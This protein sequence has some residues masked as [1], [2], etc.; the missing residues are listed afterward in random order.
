M[1]ERERPQRLPEADPAQVARKATDGDHPMLTL[2]R[3]AGNAAFNRMIQPKLTV[4]HAHDPHEDEADRV[5]AEVMR[6]LQSGLPAEDEVQPGPGGV[7]RRAALP[8]IQLKS[9]DPL[10]GAAV[11]DDLEQQISSSSGRT[12]DTGTRGRMEG[13]FGADFSN[14]RIH[15]D[16]SA[17]AMSESLQA[18]AFTTGN[19]VFFRKGGY[20]PSSSGGQ[21]LLAHELTHVVQQQGGAAS[22]KIRR[23]VPLKEFQTRTDEGTF[24]A[25]S[26]AQKE[27]EKALTAY[28]KLGAAKEEK[29]KTKPGKPA[30]KIVIPDNK[31]DNAIALLEQMKAIAEMWIEAKTVD[32]EVGP[33][34]KPTA[35]IDPSRAKRGAGMAWFLM[36]CDG[37]LKSM[38]ARRSVEAV[39]VAQDEVVVDSK[40]MQKL[41]DKYQGSLSGGL[42]KAGFVLGK[43]C[44]NDG[45]S[46]SFELNLK[47]PVAPGA[48]IGGILRFEAKKDGN[49][50]VACE[51]MFQ[52]G[53]SVGIA[54]IH[55]ALGGYF[56]SSAKTPEGAM[57]LL[58]Y[59]FYR[60]C[61]ESSVIP[62][63]VSS[64]IWGGNTGEFGKKKADKWSLQVEKEELEDDD[65]YVETG[66]VG[67]V[68]ADLEL[69]VAQVGMAAKGTAGKRHDKASLTEAKGGAGKS[70]TGPKGRGAEAKTGANVAGLELSAKVAAFAS[71][72]GGDAKFGLSWREG[73]DGYELASLDIAAGVQGRVPSGGLEASIVKLVQDFTKGVRTILSKQFQA[74]NGA[75]A[76]G[77]KLA[78]PALTQSKDIA[79]TT[80]QSV[81]GMPL[82]DYVKRQL[83]GAEDAAGEGA[84]EGASALKQSGSVGLELGFSFQ[85]AG[86]TYKTAFELRHLATMSAEIPQLLKAELVRKSRLVALKGE[87]K[88]GAPV[89]WTFV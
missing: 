44:A 40:G 65:S 5:A 68:G 84:K 88:G 85:K 10:G 62:S 14:V 78:F 21:E 86:D 33:D 31:L 74:A 6:R 43:A 3:Q 49:T 87:S 67:E 1:N 18:H 36:A 54:D 11:P 12:M 29:G 9:A 82:A 16:A 63:E 19:D 22:R 27:I 25:K 56:K 37:E 53:G 42:S 34:G 7:Q 70:N 20:D 47:V 80:L 76:K 41:K 38:E 66:G 17:G 81:E 75:A 79:D 58:S 15:D 69:G 26:S 2:Q 72:F 71:Q 50:E 28:A 60:R 35:M 23:F 73:K 4:G 64:M 39:A 55:G 52:G 48:Y 46:T 24:T 77:K 61:K 51:A 32:G 30:A 45:D 8:A 57:K 89:S 59:G 83:G 13:A